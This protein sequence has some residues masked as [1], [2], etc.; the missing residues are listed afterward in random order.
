MKTT[1]LKLFKNEASSY[2]GDLLKTRKGRSR[3]RPLASRSTMHLVLRS[4]KAKGNWSFLRLENG[5]KI[6]AIVEKFANKH[7]VKVISLANVGNHLHFHIK[8]ANRHSY[9]PFI[10]AVTSAIAMSITGRNRWTMAGRR[11]AV[12][13][14]KSSSA[15]FAMSEATAASA[16]SEKFWDRRP[17]TRIVQS[18][19]GFLN[20]S[21]Y[22]KLNRWEGFGYTKSQARML[23]GLK[24]KK[25]STA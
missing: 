2:G 3:P 13:T 10:R 1:Q 9:R 22:I 7:G 11:K 19:L 6:R 14:D 8:L 16:T 17:F 25:L 21:D 23:L 12:S 18:Y 15:T 4:T 5:K 20:L 24:S